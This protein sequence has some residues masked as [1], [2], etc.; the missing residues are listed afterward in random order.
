MQEL[1]IYINIFIVFAKTFTTNNKTSEYF[2]FFFFVAEKCL[3]CVFMRTLMTKAKRLPSSASHLHG[4]QMR[5]AGLHHMA[6]M[7]APP[8]DRCSVPQT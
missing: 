7:W 3:Y 1:H 8:F 2:S 5:P 4:M 6:Q